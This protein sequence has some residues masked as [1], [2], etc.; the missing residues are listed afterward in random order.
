[1]AKLLVTGTAGFI[2]YHTADKLLAHGHE[3]VGFDN[4]NDYY[5]TQLKRD[6]LA[7]LSGQAGFRFVEGD[8]ADGD[9]LKG[10]FETEKFE[11]VIHLA[12]Q[13]GVRYST[14]NPAAYLQANVVGFGHILE[15]CR[16]NGVEHL[17]YAST[18]SAYGA[19]T[20]MPF[21]P[22]HS[23]N[24]PVSFYAATKKANEMMAHSYSHLYR[25]P[26]TG[27]RF[28]TVYGPWGRPDMA[29][30][31]FANAISNGDP[32]K[33][34]NEGKMRRDFTFVDDIVDGVIKSA[35]LTATPNPD[36]DSDNPDPASSNAPYRL[37]NIG[38]NEPVELMRFISLIEKELGR[39]AEMIM[40]PMQPGDVVATFA[41]VDDLKAATGFAPST[42][43]E[44]G[45]AK[46]IAWFKSY[47]G[48]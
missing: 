22:H 32:I 16:H 24:H 30:M 14:E 27:L 26:T 1:M 46:F 19:N 44:D 11:R 15:G 29:P 35:F 23:A 8:L 10:L 7:N 6:R 31:L 17:T 12:A 39:K 2:G 41:D 9:L 13:A 18:S 21:S 34:F 33:V 37:Y 20:L 5:S 28:F 40:M 38:N 36:W 45:V 4:V 43:I 42:S 48:K 47:Y 25:L 3:V